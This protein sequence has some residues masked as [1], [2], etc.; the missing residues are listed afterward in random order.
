MA[1][2]TRVS[3]RCQ[4]RLGVANKT[5]KGRLLTEHDPTIRKM[6]RYL[7]TQEPVGHLLSRL[8]AT[9]HERR[10]PI[11]IGSPNVLSECKD[12]DVET[13]GMHAEIQSV[14]DQSVEMS[15]LGPEATTGFPTS[16]STE[17]QGSVAN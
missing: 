6:I 4:L 7:S 12:M 2:H 10:R 8:K 13:D 14:G 3:E 16:S 5:G 1:K 11:A 9:R 17:W 15:V